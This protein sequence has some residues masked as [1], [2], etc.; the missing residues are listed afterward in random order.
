MAA[1]YMHC[2]DNM[3]RVNSGTATGS[4]IICDMLE[5]NKSAIF[6]IDFESKAKICGQF[7]CFTLFRN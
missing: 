5:G 6:Y 7:L 4:D 3:A 1:V 2:N